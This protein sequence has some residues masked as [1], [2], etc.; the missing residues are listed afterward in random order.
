MD[1]GGLVVPTAGGIDEGGGFLGDGSLCLKE[2]EYS[3]AVHCDAV[4]YGPLQEDGAEAG[5]LDFYEME[6]TGGGIPRGL[7][8][9]GGGSSG[10]VR[11]EVNKI[12]GAVG[13]GGK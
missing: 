9:D 5:G 12:V 7:K 10:R 3:C 6:V 1:R 11:G 8:G 13:G 4:N 2:T